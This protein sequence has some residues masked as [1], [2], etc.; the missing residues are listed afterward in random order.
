MS[1]PDLTIRDE[2][3]AVAL[4]AM[5][6]PESQAFQGELERSPELARELDEYLEVAALLAL[7]APVTAAPASLR[8]RIMNNV[9]GVRPIS[10]AAR[11]DE[12][13]GAPPNV[14]GTA[15]ATVSSGRSRPLAIAL[16]WIAAA[17]ALLGVVWTGRSLDEERGARVAAEGRNGALRAQVASLDSVVS[18][19][20]A[21]DVQTVKLSAQGA[22]P[23]A[24]LYWNT[25]SRQVVFAAFNL[26]PA[27]KGRT[28]QLWGIERGKNPVSLGTFNTGSD[29]SARAS[30]RAPAGVKL[31]VGAVTVEPEG[32]SPQPTTTPFLVGQFKAGE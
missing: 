9:A 7:A 13:Q 14:T 28:Y 31:A 20:L 19:L 18:A 11:S 4:G 21:P 24:R 26:Q 12:S 29:A 32:G 16:P 30:F 27:P 23:S 5:S 25:Q 22:P 6:A 8:D 3:A 17:A 1:A 2:A 10:R 15:S